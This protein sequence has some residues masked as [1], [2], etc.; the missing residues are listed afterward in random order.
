MG[1]P[2]IQI[3]L[4]LITQNLISRCPK[5][6][7]INPQEDIIQTLDLLICLYS[8]CRR[9]QSEVSKR[10]SWSLH[11]STFRENSQFSLYSPCLDSCKPISQRAPPAPHPRLGFGR[12]YGHP[13]AMSVGAVLPAKSD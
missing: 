8:P 13:Y 11:I 4:R 12:R 9:S 7:A 5:T 2:A 6:S 3:G 1:N 10:E